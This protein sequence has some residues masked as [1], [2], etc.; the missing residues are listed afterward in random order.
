MSRKDSDGNEH[1]TRKQRV[2][3]TRLSKA[4][5]TGITKLASAFAQFDFHNRRRNSVGTW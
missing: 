1:G 3:D 4:A 5:R 2:K